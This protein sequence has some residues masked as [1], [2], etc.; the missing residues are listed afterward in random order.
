MEIKI[1]VEGD[2]D[3]K[4][5]TDYIDHS[6]SLKLEKE[7]IVTAGGWTK[8]GAPNNQG[9][10]IRNAISKNTDEGGV[11]LLIFDADEDYN[12]RFQDIEDWKREYKLEFITFL[13]PNN[14][15]SGD[16]ETLLENIINPINSPIFECWKNYEICLRS[17][18]IPERKEPLTT[19]ARKTKIYGYLEALLGESK[20]QKEKIKEVNRNYKDKNH[21]DLDSIYLK[22][23]NNFLGNYLS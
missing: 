22:N 9:E 16:L 2:A 21:W 3:R 11:N 6:F 13:F 19:P 1:F 15:E 18:T 5:L 12:Q 4:F 17:K 8:M 20:S 10:S 14:S 23:L 7:D